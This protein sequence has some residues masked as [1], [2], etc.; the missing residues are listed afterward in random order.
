[1][2]TLRDATLTDT[3]TIVALNDAVVE[4]TSPMD[5]DRFKVLFDISSHCV[6]AEQDGDVIG[7][8]LAMQTGDAYENA[9]FDW[10]SQRLNNFVYIDRIAIAE[11]GRGH[12][13][14]GKLYAHV[15]DAARKAGCLVMCAEMDLVP[16]NEQSLKFHKKSGFV[17]LGEREYES[18]KIVSMQIVGL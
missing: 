6:V 12:G 15:V 8:V 9:N 16:P 17:K 10:F 3:T 5:A 14:G 1:M 13:L 7:F 2:I 11:A 18:G 4:V